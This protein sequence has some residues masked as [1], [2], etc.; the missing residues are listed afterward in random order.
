MLLIKKMKYNE[1]E[2]LQQ[3]AGILTEIK[4]NKPTKLRYSEIIVNGEEKLQIEGCK[5]YGHYANRG[6]LIGI[7]EFERKV[8]NIRNIPHKLH[9][10]FIYA[11]IEYF[12]KVSSLTEIK[13]NNPH[14]KYKLSTGDEQDIKVWKRSVNPDEFRDEIYKSLVSQRQ[15]HLLDEWG[16]T[17][18]LISFIDE[19]T[20]KPEDEKY[21]W[22]DGEIEEIPKINEIRINNPTKDLIDLYIKRKYKPIKISGEGVHIRYEFDSGVIIDYYPLANPIQVIGFGPGSFDIRKDI[23]LYSIQQLLK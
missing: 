8:L 15:Q 20:G 10:T 11:P 7:K 12:Q 23:I 3:L 18:S 16:G 21:W 4:V 17:W 22:N 6:E 14:Q 19:E 1:I 5:Y 9:N 2:R 13:V